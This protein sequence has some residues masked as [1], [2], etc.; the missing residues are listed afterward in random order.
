MLTALFLRLGW[1][2]DDQRWLWMR[3]I[4]AA[5]LIASGV[6]DVPYWAA[7]LGVALTPVWLHRIQAL[8][9][10]LLWMSGQYS[11]SSLPG[12]KVTG[13]LLAGALTAGLA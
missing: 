5:S 10:A 8:A 9:V 13:L 2:R 4:A 12:R 7:E 11:T 6:I 3:L 1:T